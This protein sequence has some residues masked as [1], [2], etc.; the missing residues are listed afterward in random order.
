[1]DETLVAEKVESRDG[2]K[3]AMMVGTM[4]ETMG[5]YLAAA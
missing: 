2:T 4:V 3:A 1:M 5:A